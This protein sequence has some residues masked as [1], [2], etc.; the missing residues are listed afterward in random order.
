MTALLGD[1]MAALT[2]LFQ[3]SVGLAGVTVTEGDAPS[4]AADSE[5]IVV[6]HDGSLAAD[7]SLAEFTVSGTF[8][9]NFVTEGHPPGQQEDGRVNVVA[10]AQSGDA[11]DLP[12][13]ITRAQALLS[14]C[15]AACTDVTSGVIVFDSAGTGRLITR[16]ASA[17]CAAILAFTVIYSGP[18]G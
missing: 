12:G 8:T 5:F 6:G 18:W 2:S 15:D 3:A 9:T 16:Q 10:V 17:G 7:G 11:G 4:V 13:R 14:A 1:A